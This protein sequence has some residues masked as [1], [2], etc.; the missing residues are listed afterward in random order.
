MRPEVECGTCLTHWICGRAG[1]GR[2]EGERLRLHEAV[3]EAFGDALGRFES[4]GAVSN[5]GTEA[6]FARVPGARGAYGEAKAASNRAAHALLPAVRAYVEA[7]AT[8]RERLWRA[9]AAVAL[10][11]VAPLGVPT[12]PFS[13]DELR[14]LLA[15]QGPEPALLGDLD[16][17]EAARRVVYATDN[18]GEVGIDGVLLELLVEAGARVTLVVKEPEFFE[19]A[20]P[21]DARFFGLDRLAHQVVTVDGF[22]APAEAPPAAAA[23]LAAADLVIAKGTGSF[24]SLYGELG[25]TPGVFLLKVKCR[26]ISRR[27]GVPVGRFVVVAGGGP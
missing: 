11:N 18:A 1:E 26:A 24:E 10:A 9:C 27:L 23:A 4:L 2:D 5:R 20:T 25:G 16:A 7:G 19:D 15:G 17:L 3:V 14:G 21:A 12:G 6:A 13:F 22:L 8:R